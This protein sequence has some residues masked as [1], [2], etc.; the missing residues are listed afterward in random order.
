MCLGRG[1]LHTDRDPGRSRATRHHCRSTCGRVRVGVRGAGRAERAS[2]R[3]GDSQ[4]GAG[5]DAQGRPLRERCGGPADPRLAGKPHGH[6]LHPAV[7]GQPGSVSGSHQPGNGVQWCSVSVG[8]STNRYAV[9]RTISGN[10]GA[11]DALFE[12]DYITSY[13]AVTGGNIWSLAPCSSGRLQAITVDMPVNADP[14]RRPGRT[15]ELKDSIAMRNAPAC[16]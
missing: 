8:G 1:W 5:A 10:C 6:G 2:E 16:P 7:V 4:G 12:V 14:V 11:A 9:Y 3:P 15:Y 13:G